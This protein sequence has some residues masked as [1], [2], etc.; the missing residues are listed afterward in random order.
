MPTGN[1]Q[2]EFGT[3]DPMRPAVTIG[4]YAGT[5][6]GDTL[7]IDT[8][9]VDWTSVNARLPIAERQ[10]YLNDNDEKVKQYASGALELG[11]G[12]WEVEIAFSV[13]NSSAVVENVV[14]ACTNQAQDTVH[15]EGKAREVAPSGS[16]TYFLVGHVHLTAAEFIRICAVQSSDT[17]GSEDLDLIDD[18]YVVKVTKVGNA[19]ETGE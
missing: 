13:T 8:A 10:T 3:R 9:P 15:F 11:P 6:S 16:C 17:G 1:Q 12:L 2:Y 7:N 4:Q 19:N 5:L 18:D 14:A